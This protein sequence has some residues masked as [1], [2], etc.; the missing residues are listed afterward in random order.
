MNQ[1]KIIEEDIDRQ[2]NER[3]RGANPIHFRNESATKKTINWIAH[4]LSRMIYNRQ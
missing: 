1:K 3:R 2:L 4:E